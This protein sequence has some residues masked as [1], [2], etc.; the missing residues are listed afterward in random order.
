MALLP[1]PLYTDYT[2][3]GP[4]P[5]WCDVCEVESPGECSCP[6]PAP[7]PIQYRPDSPWFNYEG[8]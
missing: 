7:K 3:E 6:P 1:D 8:F 2:Q 5:W 4:D